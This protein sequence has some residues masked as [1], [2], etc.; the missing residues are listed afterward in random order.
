MLDGGHLLFLGIE[1]VRGKALSIEQR[2]RFT[3]VGMVFVIGL[4]LWAVGNDL[5]RV[6]LRMT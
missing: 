5:L 1:A 3:T 6:I 2:L 4:M